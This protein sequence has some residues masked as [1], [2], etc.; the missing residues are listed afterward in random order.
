MLFKKKPEVPT[1]YRRISLSERFRSI[2]DHKEKQR[3]DEW[4]AHEYIRDEVRAEKDQ[5]IA[6]KD[7]V[8]AELRRQLSAVGGAQFQNKD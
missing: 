1:E 2:A 7:Q 3:R 8:I 5:V 4:A 6:E